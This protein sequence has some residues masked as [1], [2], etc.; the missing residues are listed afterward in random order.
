MRR[1]GA[2]IASYSPYRR[3]LQSCGR[4][5]SGL[6]DTVTARWRIT[7]TSA[8]GDEA[9]RIVGDPPHGVDLP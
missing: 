6:A 9:S 4:E 7:E 5:R 2:R 1:C 3:W 8:L